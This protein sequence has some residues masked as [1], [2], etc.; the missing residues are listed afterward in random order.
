MREIKHYKNFEKSWF[1]LQG[2]HAI[3]LFRV[4]TYGG[5]E[6]SSVSQKKSMILKWNKQ[7]IPSFNDIYVKLVA[8]FHIGSSVYPLHVSV[9]MLTYDVESLCSGAYCCWQLD[10]NLFSRKLIHSWRKYT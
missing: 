6:L 9:S 7:G 8:H 2:E 5:I 4:G 3:T 10:T 1:K